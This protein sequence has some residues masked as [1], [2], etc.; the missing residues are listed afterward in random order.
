LSF[1]Y[2]SP[3][4]SQR[5][6]NEQFVLTTE[7]GSVIAVQSTEWQLDL[8]RKVEPTPEALWLPTTA[9]QEANA[10]GV[11]NPKPN[12]GTPMSL[13]KEFYE[14]EI[15]SN[16]VNNFNRIPSGTQPSAPATSDFASYFKW[17]DEEI[18]SLAK[19]A[20]RG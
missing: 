14:E 6:A 17:M 7:H 19:A 2:G 3:S 8:R 10:R 20:G 5:I 15:H 9:T 12:E 13:I 4:Q 18:E 16:Y 11:H 1:L